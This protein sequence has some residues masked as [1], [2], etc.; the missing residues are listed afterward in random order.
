[1]WAVTDDYFPNWNNDE[2]FTEEE[3]A[4]PVEELSLNHL[5]IRFQLACLV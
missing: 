1:M 2:H 3:V 5:Y 4:I